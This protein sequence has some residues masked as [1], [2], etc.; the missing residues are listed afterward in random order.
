MSNK[1]Q[2]EP[3]AAPEEVPAEQPVAAPAPEEVPA[4][5]PVASDEVEVKKGT[6]SPGLIA[7]IVC[8]CVFLFRLPCLRRQP[9]VESVR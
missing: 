7:G 6:T 8:G 1:V 4:E 5:Q 3:V 9:L 2:P